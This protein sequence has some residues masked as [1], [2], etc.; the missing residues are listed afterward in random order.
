M[1]NI[2][3]TKSFKLAVYM[4]GNQKAKKLALVLPGRLD[5]KD[6]HHMKSHVDYL[7][8]KGFLAVSF[9]P[10]GTWESPGDIALYTMT[11]YLKAINEL[12]AYF[13][14]KPTVLIGHSRGGTMAMLAGTRNKHVTHIIAIMSSPV[15]STIIEAYTSYR[16]TPS[17]GKKEFHLPASYYKDAAQYDLRD[18]LAK[19]TK[20]KLFF[21]G[22]KDTMVTPESVREAFAKSAKPKQ[23]YELDCS[24]DYRRYPEKIEEVNKEIGKFLDKT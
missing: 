11:N 8:S 15:A 20:P 13:G 24:H 1:V 19:C 14:N 4:Q 3:T 5:T 22:K 2:I 10:P 21:L 16:D 6:Y 9:D 12:I 23:L 7:A 18:A 17:G